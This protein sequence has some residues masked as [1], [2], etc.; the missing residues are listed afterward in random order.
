MLDEA[1]GKPNPEAAVLNL[2]VC[3]PACGSGHFLVA[4]AR[5]IARRLASV[6]S[7]DDEP[8]PRD[9]QEALRDVVGC[10]IYGVDLNTMA[11]ELCKVSLWM[12]AI[13]P[14]SRSP[15][16]TVTS[17]V[18]MRCW[19][20][21]GAHGSWHTRRR[22]QANRRGR[23]EGCGDLK[24]QNKKER[25]A[26]AAGQETMFAL[27]DSATSKD[28]AAIAEKTRA[29]E[30]E[31]DDDITVLRTKEERWENLSRSPEF[32]DAWFRADSWCAAFV[33]PSSP[34]TVQAPPSRMNV[35]DNCRDTSTA[36]PAHTQ[37]CARALTAAPLLPLAPGFS[38]GVRTGQPRTER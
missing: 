3:D 6:R 5:R 1:C 11:V 23:Q 9:V 36:Q 10:C 14:G 19:A 27:F 37:D 13:E 38:R 33:W 28:A 8:S 18:E 12:E 22:F 16:S 35:G 34:A 25:K 29:I 24:K 21:A 31:A 20:H 30:D 7:G 32:K 2:R 4:A 17:S 26:I 15:F